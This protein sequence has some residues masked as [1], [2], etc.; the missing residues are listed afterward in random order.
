MI[1]MK[2]CWLYSSSPYIL[3]TVFVVCFQGGSSFVDLF[4][5]LLCYAFVRVCLYVPCGHLLGKV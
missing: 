2:T 3:S 1:R 4:S 5:V